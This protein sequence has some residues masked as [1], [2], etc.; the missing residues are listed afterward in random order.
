M[1]KPRSKRELRK[2][3]NS[4]TNLQELCDVLN[5]ISNE[6]PTD[7]YLEGTNAE[8]DLYFKYSTFW[9]DT[10]FPS[11]G[12]NEPVNKLGVTS[13]DDTHILG[14][15]IIDS[16]AEHEPFCLIPRDQWHYDLDEEEV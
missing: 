8:R 13:W 16:K 6:L 4:T 5:K 14:D 15:Q 1:K 10:K 3:I 7:E 11:F 12:N 9:Y 2:E